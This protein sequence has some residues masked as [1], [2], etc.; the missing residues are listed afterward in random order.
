MLKNLPH[1]INVTRASTVTCYIASRV[2]KQ[3]P[4]LMLEYMLNLSLLKGHREFWRTACYFY[5]FTYHLNF[6]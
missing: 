4:R 5:D 3:T 1:A 2:W 6:S